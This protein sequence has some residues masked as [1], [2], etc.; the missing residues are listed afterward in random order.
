MTRQRNA[1]FTLV[2]VLLATVLLAAGLALAFSTVRAAGASVQRGELRAAEADRMR[3]VAAFLRRAIG[4]ARPV[5]FGNDPASGARLLFVGEPQRMRFVADLP[6]YL[7]HGGAYLHDL[8]VEPVDGHPQL[9]ATLAVVLGGTPQV[10]AAPRPPELLAGPLRDARFRYR[11]LQTDGTL[12]AWQDRWTQHQGLPVQVEV[13][14]QP[15]QGAPWP[16][17]V[18]AVPLADARSAIVDAVVR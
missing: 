13:R 9:L 3:S 15:R 18:I 2:E 1:G 8:R 4:G 10:E 6:D 11:G 16:P 7:G 12:G 14:V 5:A 17:L